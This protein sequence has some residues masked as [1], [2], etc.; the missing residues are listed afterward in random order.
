MNTINNLK[1]ELIQTLNSELLLKE[2]EKE[3]E[4]EDHE[5]DDDNDDDEATK[6]KA[7]GHTRS[8]GRA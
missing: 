6:G 5:D 3:E 7:T 1:F 4:E 8:C 2:E